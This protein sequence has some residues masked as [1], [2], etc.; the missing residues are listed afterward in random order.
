MK[1]LPL[2]APRLEL[3]VFSVFVYQLQLT[4]HPHEM[5]GKMV[6][7]NFEQ[8]ANSRSKPRRRIFVQEKKNGKG[9][10]QSVLKVR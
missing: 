7:Q 6:F 5:P 1:I 9:A 3:A 10:R 8:T 4:S 2:Q